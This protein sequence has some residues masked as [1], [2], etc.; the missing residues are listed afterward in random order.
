M[1]YTAT[2]TIFLSLAISRLTRSLPPS[3]LGRYCLKSEAPALSHFFRDG[4][5]LVLG[6]HATPGS[7]HKSVEVCEY[8]YGPGVMCHYPGPCTDW[9]FHVVPILKR[10]SQITLACLLPI[11]SEVLVDAKVSVGTPLP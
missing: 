1:G 10:Y 7:P 6:T 11:R 9:E 2:A 5:C 4:T 8:T 3:N